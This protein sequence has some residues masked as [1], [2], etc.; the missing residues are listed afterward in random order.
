MQILSGINFIG[1]LANDREGR[2]SDFYC[3]SCILIEK[4]ETIRV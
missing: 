4:M 2:R 3:F 1:N